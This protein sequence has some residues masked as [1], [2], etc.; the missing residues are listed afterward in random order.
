VRTLHVFLTHSTYVC[1]HISMN[2]DSTF[3][4]PWTYG[5]A[6]TVPEGTPDRNTRLEAQTL[7]TKWALLLDEA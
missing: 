4:R 2:K 7:D 5:F 3:F 6:R 1:I